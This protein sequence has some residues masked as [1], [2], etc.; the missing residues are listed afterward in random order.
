[1]KTIPRIS[2]AEW[3]VMKLFW[4][5]ARLTSSEI[6]QKLQGRTR[7]HP[8]TIKSLVNRLL[9]KGALGYVREGRGYRYYP[10]VEEGSCLRAESE[11]FLARF[12]DGSLTPMLAHFI[13]ERPLSPRELS[14]LRRLLKEKKQ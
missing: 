14:E 6:I 1:V 5:S 7:W 3:E 11:S 4:P 10:R 8:P 9:K 12:F 2:E 13:N